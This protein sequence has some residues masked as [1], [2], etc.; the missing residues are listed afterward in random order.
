M[1]VFVHQKACSIKVIGILFGIIKDL[2][3]LRNP[4][5]VEYN[6]ILCPFAYKGIQFIKENN[7]TRIVITWLKDMG[8]NNKSQQ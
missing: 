7:Q 6:N 2:K 5:I 8:E 4:L 3:P 1:G